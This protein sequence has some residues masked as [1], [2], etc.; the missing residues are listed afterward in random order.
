MDFIGPL[1]QDEGFDEIVTITNML[2]ADY[3]FLPC[4]MTDSASDFALRFFNGWYCE[5]GLPE[6]IFS[7]RDKLFISKFWKALTK[8][9]GVKLKMSTAY[10]PQADGTS[11]RTNKTINQAI[12]YHV[13]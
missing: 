4:K 10:H 5:H 3:Q 13:S 12:R 8:L 9:T 1:P 7:D 6:V 2:G 11:E